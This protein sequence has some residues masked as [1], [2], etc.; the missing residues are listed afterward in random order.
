MDYQIL[1][2]S[3]L[4]R[5]NIKAQQ[6]VL[7]RYLDAGNTDMS[8]IDQGQ[9]Y[10]DE[11]VGVR[12]CGSGDLPLDP[13]A[14]FSMYRR[15][16]SGSKMGILITLQSVRWSNGRVSCGRCYYYSLPTVVTESDIEP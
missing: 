3:I 12:E 2:L 8:I 11:P 10:F 1:R 6:S 4:N 14:V 7:K 9:A 16:I 13:K 5:P 15:T